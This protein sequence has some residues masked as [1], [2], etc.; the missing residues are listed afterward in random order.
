MKRI[1]YAFGFLVLL[2]GIIVLSVV[3]NK[4]DIPSMANKSDWVNFARPNIWHSAVVQVLM[5]NQIAGGYLI[6]SGDS[7]NANTNVQW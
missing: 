1:F 3:G 6:S 2:L 5:L 4:G 7:I